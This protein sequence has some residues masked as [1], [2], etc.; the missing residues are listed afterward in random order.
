MIKDTIDVI[1]CSAL[2]IPEKSSTKYTKQEDE[3]TIQNHE[4]LES[5]GNDTKKDTLSLSD[6]LDEVVKALEYKKFT[7]EQLTR[8]A[9]ALGRSQGY[10]IFADGVLLAQDSK[11]LNFLKQ[12]KP[13]EWLA[14]RNK[15]LLAFLCGAGMVEER[16]SVKKQVALIRSVE[17]VYYL[18]NLN[19]ITPMAFG[20]NLLTFFVTGS[21]TAI[22]YNGASSPSG[23]YTS[24]LSTLN[25]L[26]LKPL[27]CPNGDVDTFFDNCQVVGKNYHVHLQATAPVSVITSTVHIVHPNSGQVQQKVDLSPAYW[28]WTGRF[29]H[30]FQD[31]EQRYLD[32]FKNLRRS[33]IQQQL[34]EV[35]K[36]QT[37][38]NNSYV[39][40]IDEPQQDQGTNKNENEKLF[41]V[42][43]EN[44]TVVERKSPK[45]GAIM[46]D[47]VKSH[48][49]KEPPLAIIGE[50]IILNPNSYERVT[51]VLDHM[52][53][54]S[55]L[56]C[57]PP[58]RKWISIGCDGL[59]YLLAA[60]VIDRTF[61]CP[62]CGECVNS[63]AEDF[64]AHLERHGLPTDLVEQNRKYKHII[65]R[66]GL[67]HFEI[68][69]VKCIFKLLWIV[70]LSS[71]AKLLGFRS[72]RALSY[73]K[74]ASDHHKSWE[75]LQIVFKAV[76][77]ELLIAFVR[78]K[79]VNG[80]Q[81]SVDKYFQWLKAVKDPNY[82][83][84]QEIV[85]TYLVALN[86]FRIGVRRNNSAVMLTG[87]QKFARLFHIM[88]MTKYRE[89]CSRDMSDRAHY[90]PGLQDYIR[91]TEAVS[92]SGHP[93]KGEGGDFVLENKNKRIKMWL[94]KGV[95]V[96]KQWIRVNR[97]LDRLDE[98][99]V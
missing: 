9:E 46:L 37:L 47:S 16:C 76:S 61:V 68:N 55:G 62:Q 23:G 72:E 12:F 70:L 40:H 73:C 20:L 10:N 91:A 29:Q 7:E 34:N 41:I 63:G 83:F 30:R 52:S 64:A 18:R 90:P 80:E 53:S 75:I 82:C 87:R 69:M 36:E 58:R 17:D 48:H 54:V 42:S 94:P 71:V 81:P 95:P 96:E 59:P 28:K 27:E 57:T 49:P 31:F 24:I 78:E 79:L 6:K 4:T 66:P 39:D 99:S 8:L 92:T 32:T 88:G 19:L 22:T 26:T 67:G 65:L 1:Y 60:K 35:I 77:K 74:T 21:K 3:C 15:I 51:Q 11:D 25:D 97:N 85:F 33:Y 44:E 56:T 86:I 50:P 45:Q 38:V 13:D 84:I 14:N 2:L 93:Q 43:V 89:I 5:I 98:V